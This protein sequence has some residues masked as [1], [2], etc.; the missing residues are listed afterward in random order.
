MSTL[1]FDIGGKMMAWTV[2]IPLVV[3]IVAAAIAFVS[4]TFI[5]RSKR[6]HSLQNEAYA[7]YLSAVA[8]SGSAPALDR[9][10]V[11]ADAALAKCKIVIYGSDQVIEALKAFEL[12]GAVTSS[13]QGRDRL[14]N[15]VM[16]MR[17]DATV[18]R[19]DISGLLLGEFQPRVQP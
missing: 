18:S 3:A 17:G 11:L 8:R 7:E 4:G 2:W 9:Q 12:S 15:L 13:D 10:K 1:T 6:K 16:A 14:I 19:A 5:E